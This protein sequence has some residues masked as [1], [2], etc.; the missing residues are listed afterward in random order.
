[1]IMDQA[2]RLRRWVKRKEMGMDLG[3]SQIFEE[4]I[5]AKKRVIVFLG[6]AD[7]AAANGNLV[8][9]VASFAAKKGKR[10]IVLDA[11]Q[12][13]V[14]S[15]IP[16]GVHP[17]LSMEDV[18][19][20]HVKTKE[21]IYTGAN[22]VKFVKMGNI[23]SQLEA[24][25]FK[26]KNNF[27]N[28]WLSLEE[29]A[30]IILINEDSPKFALATNE[31]VILTSDSAEV[32]TKV[33]GMIKQLASNNKKLS[34]SLVM[35]MCSTEREALA[36]SKRFIATVK[37]F[38]GIEMEELGFVLLIPDAVKAFKARVPFVVK[39]P[40]C[41]ASVNVETITARLLARAASASRWS[42]L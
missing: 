9:N 36:Q 33:Y 29:E 20:D 35:N 34:L 7:A 16:L 15:G 8:A 26:A 19:N 13:K 40:Y 5:A 21:I 41:S 2:E 32:S 12:G 25:D 24:L 3:L 14:D 31:I 30:D 28:H 22:N 37:K 1:M 4:K 42:G 38:Q 18:I 10:C 6:S 39:Y 17:K 23:L 11:Y 27:F